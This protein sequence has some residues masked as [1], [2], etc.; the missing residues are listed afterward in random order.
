[1]GYRVRLASLL[2]ATAL[3]P[4]C[5]SNVGSGAS[6]SGAASGDPLE[7][8]ALEAQLP[9]AVEG[10]DLARYSLV[11]RDWVNATMAGLTATEID[12]L[13]ARFTAHGGDTIDQS[14]LAVAWA[15]P[16]DPLTP[17][18]VMFAV[19]RPSGRS[20]ADLAEFLLLQGAHYT[21]ENMPVDLSRYT[22]RTIDGKT[23]F[24]GATSMLLPI[25]PPRGQPYLYQTTTTMFIIETDDAAAAEDAI[26]QLPCCWSN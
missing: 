21:N 2:L 1:M 12:D 15:A 7:A 5:T 22:A 3:I 8:P 6:P 11:G 26:R 4:G 23:V 10:H 20:E 14:H 24:L 25:Q 17:S 19:A 18:F 13:L 16:V 9:A